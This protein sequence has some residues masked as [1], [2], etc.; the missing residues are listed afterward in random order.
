[1]AVKGIALACIP[2][3]DEMLY[4]LLIAAISECAAW[5]GRDIGR[6]PRGATARWMAA[7]DLTRTAAAH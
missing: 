2:Q 1:T 7:C 3:P 5:A 4:D 6:G